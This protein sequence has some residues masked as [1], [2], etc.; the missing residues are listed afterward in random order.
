MHSLPYFLHRNPLCGDSKKEKG[1]VFVNCSTF[2]DNL[3]QRS[4]QYRN[5]SGEKQNIP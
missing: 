5:E 3:C 2:Q 4:F 1:K